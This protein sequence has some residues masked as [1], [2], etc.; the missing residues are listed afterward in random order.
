MGLRHAVLAALV[1]RELSGYQLTKLFHVGVADFWYAVPQQ[2]YAELGRAEHA[3][4]ITGHEVIQHGRPNKRVF[5]I[6]EAGL[7]E[8]AEFARAPSKPQSLR[9]DLLVKVYAVDPADALPVIAQLRER[10][11]RARAKLELLEQV[12]RRLRGELEEAEFLSSGTRVG[13]YLTCRRGQLFEQEQLHWCDWAA[14]VLE[15]RATR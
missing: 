10:A 15:R 7:T 3:G 8:L 13:P 4:L 14:D 9:D 11:A 1:D 12:L 5:S 6:T 2:L